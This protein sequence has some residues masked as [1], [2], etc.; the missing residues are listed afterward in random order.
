MRDPG[1]MNAPH[2]VLV[3][4]VNSTPTRNHQ[5]QKKRAAN[6]CDINPCQSTGKKA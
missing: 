2:G 6:R 5:K 1:E 3:T 4:A